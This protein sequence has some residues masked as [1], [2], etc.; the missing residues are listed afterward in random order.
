MKS[1]SDLCLLLLVDVC[2]QV[3]AAAERGE[4]VSKETKGEFP[5]TMLK[6]RMQEVDRILAN[7]QRMFTEERNARA[8]RQDLPSTS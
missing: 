1:A 8:S 4:I 6:N 3:I 5:I 2:H 7:H